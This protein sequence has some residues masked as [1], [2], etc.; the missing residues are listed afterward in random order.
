MNPMPKQDIAKI[1]GALVL[2][3]VAVI[4]MFRFY[5]SQQVHAVQTINTPPGFSEKEQST[6]GAANTGESPSDNI[7]PSKFKH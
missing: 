5:A 2:V 3:L 1:A 4:L 6:K 7:D